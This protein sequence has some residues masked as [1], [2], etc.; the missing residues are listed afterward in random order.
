MPAAEMCL[1]IH[2]VLIL[3][4]E[5]SKIPHIKPILMDTVP[6]VQC[7]KY[8]FR[9]PH[10]GTSTAALLQFGL[11]LMSHAASPVVLTPH[12]FS[13]QHEAQKR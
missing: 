2:R 13:Q 3:T 5:Q 4:L 6:E 9:R 12:L 1:K 11:L 7:L 8:N 10:I